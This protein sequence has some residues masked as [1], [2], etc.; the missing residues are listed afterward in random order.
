VVNPSA[1]HAMVKETV[2]R[3]ALAHLAPPATQNDWSA[4]ARGFP[5]AG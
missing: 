5:A 4:A 1:N 3:R 2:A